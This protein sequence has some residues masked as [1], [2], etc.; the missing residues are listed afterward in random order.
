MVI[1]LHILLLVF[2]WILGTTAF[3]FVNT[4]ICRQNKKKKILNEHFEC[5]SCG[6]MLKAIETF[7]VFSYILLKGKC[8]YC[9]EKLPVRD[10]INE[11]I[12]GICFVF[13]FFRFGDAPSLASGF[14]IGIPLDVIAHFNISRLLFLLTVCLFFC[15]MD[16]VIISDYDTM[17]IPNKY[18]VATLVI[19]VISLLTLPGVS[20]TEH[21]IGAFVISVP[22][23][24]IASVV[25]GGFGGGD[26]KLS[27][28]VGL[29]LGWKLTVVSFA[30]SLLISGI[31]AIV[32]LLAKKL[33]SKDH[34][35][36]GPYLC[37]GYIIAIICGMDILNAYLKLAAMIRG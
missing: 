27:V 19:A 6:T 30:I 31:Y 11:I 12:G 29:M 28:A 36:F 33:K 8:R 35:A 3:S 15:V 13:L 7:P 37:T 9:N 20:L 17:K 2:I 23:F 5:D 21:I 1:F 18:V 25:H 32:L 16:L 4:I 34:F 10:F 24:I 14:T 22:M 26:V